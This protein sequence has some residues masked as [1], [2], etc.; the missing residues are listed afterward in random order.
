MVRLILLVLASNTL[1]YNVRKFTIYVNARAGFSSNFEA[2]ETSSRGTANDIT[3][4]AVDKNDPYFASLLAVFI[5]SHVGGISKKHLTG[6]NKVITSTARYY[7]YYHM[8]RFTDDPRK[9]SPFIT[10]D[11]KALVRNNIQT[12]RIWT[13]KFEYTRTEINYWYSHHPNKQNV[14]HYMYRMSCNNTGVLGID[15]QEASK[16]A[17]NSDTNWRRF[18]KEDSDGLTQTGQKL[19]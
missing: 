9:M 7:I 8:K 3:K 5:I 14:R 19:F 10:E 16:I 11:L 6:D 2:L 4:L 1:P 12:K 15:Y 13:N 18:I 17:N